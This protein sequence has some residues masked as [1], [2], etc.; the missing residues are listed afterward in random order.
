MTLLRPLVLSLSLAVACCS[1]PSHEPDFVPNPADV[2]GTL[3]AVESLAPALAE[4]VPTDAR[5]EVIAEG[6][7]GR[8]FGRRWEEVFMPP[9]GPAI[10]AKDNLV[11]ALRNRASASTTQTL[12][13][14]QVLVSA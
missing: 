3:G 14:T 9:R 11:E 7:V 12:V 5:L 4:L 6:A 13:F 1:T 2:L 10:L 8:S